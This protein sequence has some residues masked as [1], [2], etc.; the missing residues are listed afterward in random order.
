MKPNG[1]YFLCPQ[2]DLRGAQNNR[3]NKKWCDGRLVMFPTSVQYNGGTTVNGEWFDGY[4]VPE[5][6]IDEGY[7]LVSIACGDQLNARPPLATRLLRKKS[8]DN[9]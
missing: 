6:L 8:V 7:E 5:P 2:P 4:K 3:K 1:K 9:A